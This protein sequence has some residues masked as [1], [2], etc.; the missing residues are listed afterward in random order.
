M[1]RGT[2]SPPAPHSLS[3]LCD[4][5]GLLLT[6]DT[7]GSSSSRGR[8]RR[9][10]RRRREEGRNWTVPVHLHRRGCKRRPLG[11]RAASWASLR[12]ETGRIPLLSFG[13]GS[14]G[15]AGRER[16]G[17]RATAR[18][19]AMMVRARIPSEPRARLRAPPSAA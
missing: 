12:P 8:R 11:R 2:F 19:R 13:V 18:W 17:P 16:S 3:L 15:A 6:G 7:R 5:G 14:T 9:K 1:T 4:Q 10:K